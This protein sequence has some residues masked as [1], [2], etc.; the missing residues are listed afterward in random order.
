MICIYK[1]TAFEKLYFLIVHT[2]VLP[3]SL[4]TMCMLGVHG[5][6][7]VTKSRGTGVTCGC[8]EL[9]LRSSKQAAGALNAEPFL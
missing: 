3:G 2:D 5:S 1:E 9:H 8:W 6:E 7:K 4:Y